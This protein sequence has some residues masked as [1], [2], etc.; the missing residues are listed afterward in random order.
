LTWLISSTESISQTENVAAH[1]IRRGPDTLSSRDIVA[2]PLYF[3]NDLGLGWD[4][5]HLDQFHSEMV[6]S[7]IIAIFLTEPDARQR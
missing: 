5:E 4:A 3:D 7:V 1:E 2:L 6:Q